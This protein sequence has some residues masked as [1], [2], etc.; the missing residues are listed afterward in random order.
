L[1]HKKKLKVAVFCSG[2]G[3][4]LEALIRS[5]KQGVL[6]AEICLV[7]SD[8]PESYAL[9][10][11]KEHGIPVFLVEPKFYESRRTYEE[12]IAKVLKA[13]DIG[14]VVLA[15]F[16]RILTPY[17][18]KA[19]RGKILNIHP[20]LLPAFRGAHAIRDAFRHGSKVTGVTV[21]FVTPELDSGPIILQEPVTRTEKDTLATLEAKIHKVEHR[22]YAKAVRLFAKKRLK[23]NGRSVRV[24]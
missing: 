16:M 23:V 14:L 8:N 20:A 11:A 21:H 6:G 7:V 19:Y 12:R 22:L 17:F 1:K 2:Y 4:N 5:Q 9:V 18:T 13:K 15:G 10:R 24:L 3:S